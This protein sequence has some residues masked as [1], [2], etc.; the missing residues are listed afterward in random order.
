V[1][2]TDPREIRQALVDVAKGESRRELAF[3]PRTGEVVVVQPGERPSPDAVV[4]TQIADEGFFGG[5]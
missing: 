1:A 4:A 5:C 3:D 2:T